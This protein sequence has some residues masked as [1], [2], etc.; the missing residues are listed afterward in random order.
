MSDSN[1]N[2][3]YFI[4]SPLCSNTGHNPKYTLLTGDSTL[5][6]MQ[7]RIL[8]TTGPLA[9]LWSQIEEARVAGRKEEVIYIPLEDYSKLI[10][11]N[12]LVLG[13][14]SNSISYTRRMGVLK[15]VIKDPRKV[16]NLLKVKKDP[17][18]MR[19]CLAKKFNPASWRQK[20]QGSEPWTS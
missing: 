10:E 8:Q 17:K 7:G 9:R 16:K 15:Q 5:V 3:F 14:A 11:Q 13:Q 20:N 18:R 1:S 19:S 6:K 2:K 12:I 4:K